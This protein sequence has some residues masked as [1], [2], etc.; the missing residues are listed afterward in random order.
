[1]FRIGFID[2]KRND[3]KNSPLEYK[4]SFNLVN[5]QKNFDN[6]I[7]LFLGQRAVFTRLKRVIDLI[8]FTQNNDLI[9]YVQHFRFY[10]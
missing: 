1:M 6:N 9:F 3:N 5:K 4:L 2:V 8:S 7:F 10:F